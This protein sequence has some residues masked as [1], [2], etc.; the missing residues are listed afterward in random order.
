MPYCLL[1]D[2]RACVKWY[3]WALDLK[4]IHY[5]WI[6]N[7]VHRIFIDFVCTAVYP[8]GVRRGWG[9]CHNH[10]RH[11]EQLSEMG[12]IW[13]KMTKQITWNFYQWTT[14]M[15]HTALM[16]R[17]NCA[18]LLRAWD[19]QGKLGNIIYIHALFHC[20]ARSSINTSASERSSWLPGTSGMDKSLHPFEAVGRN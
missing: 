7:L 9:V 19:I 16:I 17:Y 13:K 15:F 8:G 5:R 10:L 1:F 3:R 4:I 18:C 6:V 11:T 14:T 2:T 20:T 12:V